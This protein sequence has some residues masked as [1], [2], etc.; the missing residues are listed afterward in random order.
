M[1]KKRFATVVAIVL[2]ATSA[3]ADIILPW[4]KAEQIRFEFFDSGQAHITNAVS[5]FHHGETLIR[6]EASLS[7][8]ERSAVF[9]GRVSALLLLPDGRAYRLA[10]VAIRV[11]PR[12]KFYGRSGYFTFHIGYRLPAGTVARLIYG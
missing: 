4:F 3:K 12:P 11:R 2:S 10:P 8:R 7:T 6:G 1:K 5:Y 9:N